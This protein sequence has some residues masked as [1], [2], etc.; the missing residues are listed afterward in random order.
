MSTLAVAI[1]KQRWEVAALCLLVG[2]AEVAAALPPDAVE[3][4]LDVL[5]GLEDERPRKR[6]GARSLGR[7][8]G[9]TGRTGRGRRR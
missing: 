1:R 4:L 5:A 2:V 3:G 8:P 6:G 9:R 7:L